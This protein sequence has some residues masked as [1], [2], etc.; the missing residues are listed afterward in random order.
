MNH[1]SRF[2]TG[3]AT[4]PIILGGLLIAAI[5]AFWLAGRPERPDEAN[6]AL[7]PGGLSI[8]RPHG[9]SVRSIDT[10]G[11]N[12]FINGMTIQPQQWVGILP[13][14][15]VKTYRHPPAAEQLGG[16]GQ[17][18]FEGQPA[19]SMKYDHN[20]YMNRVVVTQR[21]DKWFQLNLTTTDPGTD[22]MDESLWKFLETFHYDASAAPTTTAAQPPET[23]YSPP[24]TKGA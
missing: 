8:V 10:N 7:G 9:W 12:Q 17:I 2:A 23:E 22:P 21:G 6:R 16:W 20:K 15:L 14:M 4:K 5:V 18:N 19:L 1:R 3:A 13:T 11:D 24:A